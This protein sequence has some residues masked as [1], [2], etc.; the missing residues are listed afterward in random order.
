MMPAAQALYGS[1]A[2]GALDEMRGASDALFS[3]PAPLVPTSMWAAPSG[4]EKENAANDARSTATGELVPRDLAG[5][6]QVI[7]I[8]II[9]III[10]LPA[11]LLLLSS[12][13]ST[14]QQIRITVCI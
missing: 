6:Q 11:I 9:I 14:R 12:Y 7:I 8:I 10:V 1:D 4:A 13:C 3:L 2:L 5:N